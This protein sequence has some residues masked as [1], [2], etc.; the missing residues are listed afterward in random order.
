MQIPL[1]P[2]FSCTAH[3][4]Q[5]ETLSSALVDLNIPPS[6][7]AT[8]AYIALS[9]VRRRESLFILS[10]FDPA[11]LRRS[12]SKAGVDILLQR[13]R[14]DL[15]DD[16]EGSKVCTRCTK[17]KRRSEFVSAETKSTAQWDRRE[18]YCLTC[19]AEHGDGRRKRW[20]LACNGARCNGAK[21][22]RSSFSRDVLERHRMFK[23]KLQC[24]TC[25]TLKACR[26]CGK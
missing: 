18:R 6:G 12:A 17:L 14:G 24:D 9:R 10:D 15:A 21:R 26:C 4:A 16:E 7:D 3:L 20:E 8:A 22:P 2:D 19:L 13:L 11:K 25:E 1:V 5:G 23:E